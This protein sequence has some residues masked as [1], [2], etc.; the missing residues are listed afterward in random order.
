M[1]RA[2][3]PAVY[4]CMCTWSTLLLM[5]ELMFRAGVKAL[6]NEQAKRAHSLYIQRTKQQSLYCL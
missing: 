2:S 4:M 3:W 5:H 6:K 1:A